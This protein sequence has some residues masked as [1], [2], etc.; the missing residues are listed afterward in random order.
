MAKGT[1]DH[2]VH[3]DAVPCMVWGDQLVLY[4][5]FRRTNLDGRFMNMYPIRGGSRN[6]EGGGGGGG[7]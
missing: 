6:V 2:W 5:W 4:G 1:L 3:I 7:S